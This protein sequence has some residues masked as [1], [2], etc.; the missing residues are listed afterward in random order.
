VE[1]EGVTTTNLIPTMLNALVNY[2]EV[3]DYDFSSLRLLLSGGSS[4]AERVAEEAMDIFGCEYAQTYGMTETC[5]YLTVSTLKEHLRMLPPEE[6]M[7]FR[8]S[9]GREF[10][11]VEL[12][13]VDKWGQDVSPDGVEVGEIVVRGDSVMKEYWNLP[14]ATDEAF[15]DGWLCTGD[16]A[17]MD[18]EGYVTIV[19]RKR[20]VIITGGE[21]VYSVEVENELYSH[22]AVLEAA[23]IGVPDEKWGEAVKAIIVLREGQE[24]TEEAII[25]YCRERMA[26]FKAP[27]SVDFVPALPRTGSAKIAKV[28]LRE[29]YWKGM[30]KRVH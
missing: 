24:T 9:T 22:P 14:E 27:K 20:D 21:N 4:V 10:I 19:D 8:A 7:R 11:T 6:Q 5:P 3:Y 1:R 25:Q 23:V 26:R 13:I 2:P 17:V 15:R 29:E 12:R 28:A 16:M 30:A 18:P